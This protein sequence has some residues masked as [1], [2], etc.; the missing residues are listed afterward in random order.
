MNIK[1][2]VEMLLTITF[3]MVMFWFTASYLDVI[4]HNLDEEPI[5]HGRNVFKT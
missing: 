1:R 5:Y 2:I 3:I 4:T